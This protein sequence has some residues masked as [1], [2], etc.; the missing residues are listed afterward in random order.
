MNSTLPLTQLTLSQLDP[1]VKTP[2]Y[3]RTQV[4]AGIAHI[5]VGGFHRSHQAYYTHQLMQSGE[6]MDWGICGIGLR[7][8]DR[9]IKDVLEQ[10]DYLYTLIVRH[11][12]GKVENHVIGSIVDFLLSED[13]PEAI[14]DKLSSPAI[15]IVSLTITEGGYN[16]N[17]AT[18]EFDFENPDIKYDLANHQ[19]PKTVFGFLCASL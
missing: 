2:S 4:Q 11:P 3:D 8:G 10:Q 19:S 9:K 16:F 13:E 12:D 15:K 14:I 6:A 7:A 18:G 17:P 5:G 1:R